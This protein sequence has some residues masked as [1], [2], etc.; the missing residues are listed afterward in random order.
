MAPHF[1][2]SKCGAAYR[3][4]LSKHIQRRKWDSLVLYNRE[5]RYS[6]H[7]IMPN[8][9]IWATFALSDCMI[10]RKCQV[11]YEVSGF[12]DMFMVCGTLFLTT[13]YPPIML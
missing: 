3:L 2:E 5:K 13:F 8:T 1:F 12:A 9:T 6:I 4:V 10:F 11:Y 7:F